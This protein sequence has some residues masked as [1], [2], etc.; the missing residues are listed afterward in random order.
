MKVQWGDASMILTLKCITRCSSS[1]SSLQ[2]G[3][4][5]GS[6]CRVNDGYIGHNEATRED[7][8]AAFVVRGGSVPLHCVLTSSAHTSAMIKRKKRYRV[9]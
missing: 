1:T 9:A 8:T 6:S 2:G 3:M 5:I 4:G 7:V